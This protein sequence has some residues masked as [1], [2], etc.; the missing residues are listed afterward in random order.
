LY[1]Y[2]GFI[3]VYLVLVFGMGELCMGVLGRDGA[4]SAFRLFARAVGTS[5]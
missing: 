3:W 1:D 5:S 2:C 4:F